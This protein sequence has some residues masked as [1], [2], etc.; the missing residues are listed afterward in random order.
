MAI[1]DLQ[2][3]L[4]QIGRIRIGAQDGR[5]PTKLEH[6][7][8]TSQRPDLIE[9]IAGL[10]GGTPRAWTNDR[11]TDRWEVFTEADSIEVLVPP[12]GPNRSVLSQYYEQ[13]NAGGCT[14]RC[15]GEYAEKA[16]GKIL[17]R[18]IPC[19]C[20]DRGQVGADRDCAAH[21]RVSVIIPAL[22]ELG[23]WRLD[24]GGWNAAE[25]MA[26]IAQF[27]DTATSL[28][29]SVPCILYIDK[30]TRKVLDGKAETLNFVVPVLSPNLSGAVAE[31]VAAGVPYRPDPS[32]H[33]PGASLPGQRAL[34]GPTMSVDVPDGVARAPRAASSGKPKALPSDRVV[35]PT[36]VP[37]RSARESADAERGASGSRA[38]FAFIN[39]LPEQFR[40][41]DA[42]E[43]RHA[44]YALAAGRDGVGFADLSGAQRGQVARWA[45]ELD[46]G[47]V[48]LTINLGSYSLD[49]A[50]VDGVARHQGG[51]EAKP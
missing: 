25:E 28:G 41:D 17:D 16:D 38:A 49:G 43:T 50:T 44:L 42:R 36:G 33:G 14:Y 32:L 6:F 7:R 12:P 20:A 26:G 30:R 11:S 46:S 21:T 29:Y 34:G 23:Q 8:F 47:Q 35:P 18:P 15:D 40:G 9:R 5:R 3:R 37:I 10:Y 4:V 13:W 27:L 39:S 31:A 24:T 51:L 45:S 1:V 22:G 2:R 48:K 19:V